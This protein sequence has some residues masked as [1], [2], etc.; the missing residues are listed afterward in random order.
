MKLK[1]MNSANSVKLLIRNIHSFTCMHLMAVKTL[2]WKM[3][4]V[5][6]RK[7][8]LFV[9]IHRAHNSF[10]LWYLKKYSCKN[11]KENLS[12][13]RAHVSLS[14]G[15]ANVIAAIINFP[16]FQLHSFVV[17]ASE[18]CMRTKFKFSAQI[19]GVNKNVCFSTVIVALLSF[20]R[21]PARH[22]YT[23]FK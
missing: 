18:T 12:N 23:K 5:A 15:A 10:S 19:Y 1:L 7:Q 17:H 22:F 21:V 8:T 16:S 2:H 3:S 20:Y 13:F 6:W 9:H 4:P 14:L 11:T